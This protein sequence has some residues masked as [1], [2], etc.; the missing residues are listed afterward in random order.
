[1]GRPEW[2]DALAAA[3]AESAPCFMCAETVWWRCHRRCIADLLVAR[4]HEVIHL[5]RPRDSRPHRLSEEAEA[6]EGLLYLCG[7]L[8]A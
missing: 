1:M 6:R 8:V 7:E 5:L 2:Q 4:G 3:L